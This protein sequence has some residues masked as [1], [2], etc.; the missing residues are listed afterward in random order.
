MAGSYEEHLAIAEAVIH[1]D[2]TLAARR[3]EEHLEVGKRL[4]LSP[5]HRLPG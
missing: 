3:I 2:A 4:L 1:G 5:R